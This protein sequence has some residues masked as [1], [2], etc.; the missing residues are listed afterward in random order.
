MKYF[1]ISGFVMMFFM[2]SIIRSSAQT[3][4][5]FGMEGQYGFII[6]HAVDLRG[7]ASSNPYGVQLSYFRLNASRQSWEVCNCFYY[8]GLQLSIHDFGN[9]EILGQANNITGFFE[10]VLFSGRSWNFT[11]KSGMGFTYLTRVYDEETNPENLFFSHPLSFLI[12]LQ[13]K[14][15]YRL[16]DHLDVNVSMIYN[17]ISNGGQRQ[18]NRG[19]NYPMLGVG[20]SYV[21]DR[22]KLPQYE[23]DEG[24]G[25][26]N[27][28][29]DLFGTNRKTGVGDER[30]YLLGL[31]A[32]AYYS[33]F[34][35]SA[36]GG[37]LEFYNDRSLVAEGENFFGGFIS[38][39]YGSHHFTFGRFAFS[40]RFAY[41][42]Q[43]P[44]SYT[45]HLF[46]QRYIIQYGLINNLQLGV[47]LKVHG[48]VAEN[49]DFRLGW[50]FR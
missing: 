34:P 21:I 27:Y 29:I 7:I 20:M 49:I 13:P 26:W 8:L 36:F 3:I 18:P 33:V 16:T 50:K 31:S 4:D 11:F 28:Y 37:G 43:K 45:D 42:L 14:L 22:Q 5:Q 30:K 35:I 2:L 39:P 19:I 9:P 24:I 48:H 32:G 12:F 17:H 15:N 10:P 6:P 38:A 40:Q 47:G 41:Y 23:P 44:S 1:L 46:Y 25:K